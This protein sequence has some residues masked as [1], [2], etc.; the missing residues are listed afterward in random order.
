MRKETASSDG[1]HPSIA[2]CQIERSQELSPNNLALLILE[3]HLTSLIRDTVL[4]IMKSEADYPALFKK[5]AACY[6]I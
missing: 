4:F 3:V 1:D 6:Y 2:V 5:R